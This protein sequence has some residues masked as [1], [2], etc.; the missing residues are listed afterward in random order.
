MMDFMEKIQRIQMEEESLGKII[1]HR[2]LPPP[3]RNRHPQAGAWDL[4]SN[5]IANYQACSG[6]DFQLPF[7]WPDPAIFFRCV[8]NPLLWARFSFCM[9]NYLGCIAES[10]IFCEMLTNFIHRVS[11]VVDDNIL[12]EEKLKSKVKA[13]G[14]RNQSRRIEHL[15]SKN[16]ISDAQKRALKKVARTRNKYVH[17]LIH[18][19][20][21]IKKDAKNLLRLSIQVLNEFLGLG[22]GATPGSIKFNPKVMKYW[23]HGVPEFFLLDIEELFFLISF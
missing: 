15:F 14:R 7:A 10:G 4:K 20:D 22:I 9:D 18:D 19:L 6:Q 16:L 11:L 17:S 23:N 1:E 21:V 2:L 13:F 5:V 3:T 8:G 12:S